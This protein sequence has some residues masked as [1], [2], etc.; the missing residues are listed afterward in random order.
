MNVAETCDFDNRLHFSGKRKLSKQT[1][2]DFG[3]NT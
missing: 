1:T 2:T 3:A